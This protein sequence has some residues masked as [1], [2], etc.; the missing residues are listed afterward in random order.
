MK[1]LSTIALAI[2]TLA[3]MGSGMV[4]ASAQTFA[5]FT[6]TSTGTPF[7]FTNSGSTSTFDASNVGVNF[8]YLV[9]NGSGSTSIVPATLNLN[10]LVDGAASTALIAGTTYDEQSLQNIDISITNGPTNYLT[11]TNATGTLIGANGKTTLSLDSASITGSD[12]SSSYLSFDPSAVDSFV[13][14]FS[15]LSG[16][17]KLGINGNGYLKTL[18][19]GGGSGTFSGTV[20]PE[21][22]SLLAILV[23][24]ATLGLVAFRRARRAS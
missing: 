6:Q 12:F 11:I 15:D 1:R 3:L 14:S 8:Q 7:V 22:S 2:A 24:F 20:V 17:Q 19:A 4:P 13:L 23:G 10:S 5:Q 18:D 9:A 16:T 21:S